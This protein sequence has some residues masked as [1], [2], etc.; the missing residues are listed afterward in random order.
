MTRSFMPTVA[1]A[2][3][4]LFTAGCAY[5][6]LGTSEPELAELVQEARFAEP[7]AAA[8]Q[9]GCSA[10]TCTAT[11]ASSAPNVVCTITAPGAL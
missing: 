3:S 10:T 6:E 1:I 7:P 9:P 5:P 11:C 2:A 8:T 4:T